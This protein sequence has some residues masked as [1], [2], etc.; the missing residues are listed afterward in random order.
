MNVFHSIVTLLQKALTHP[1]DAASV[2]KD[3]MDAL[4]SAAK[5]VAIIVGG[6]WTYRAFVR[7]R[8]YQPRAALTH[9]ISHRTLSD[10]RR[11]LVVDVFLENLGEV[12]IRLRMAQTWVQ[13]IVPLPPDLD[14][15]QDIVEADK[16]EANWPLLDKIHKQEFPS[17]KYIIDPKERD[18][19]RHNFVFGSEI[20]TI[21]VYTYFQHD[22][23]G[24]GWK[25]KSTYELDLVQPGVAVSKQQNVEAA[26]VEKSPRRSSNQEAA[27]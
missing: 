20:K 22:R 11:L 19:F 7:S 5:I 6:F 14:G 25:L 21:Q 9:Q 3:T 26:S 1:K 17:N 2:L 18:Q 15:R 8:G 12:A 10:G 16:T 23:G 24:I 13:Q 27:G 4:E